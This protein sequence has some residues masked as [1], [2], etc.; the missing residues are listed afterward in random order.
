MKCNCFLIAGYSDSI[1]DDVPEH[2]MIMLAAGYDDE[3]TEEE[4][5]PLDKCSY[6]T[7]FAHKSS[8]L[9]NALDEIQSSWFE[10]TGSPIDLKVI[11]DD[12]GLMTRD[13]RKTFQKLSGGDW[14][15]RIPFVVYKRGSDI[16][17]DAALNFIIECS[18]K[19]RWQ[20]WK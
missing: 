8:D 10:L 11:S 4:M 14:S 20:F 7:T 3:E 15:Y 17:K 1:P 6:M 2:D 5:V 16:A 18:I 9:E 12:L 13:Q 19:K